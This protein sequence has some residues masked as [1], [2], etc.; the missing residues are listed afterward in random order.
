MG[1][2]VEPKTEWVDATVGQGALGPRWV[3][4]AEAF[5]PRLTTRHERIFELGVGPTMSGEEVFT[6][7]I[8]NVVVPE[9]LGEDGL[10]AVGT[11]VSAGDLLVGR[12]IFGA[13]AGEAPAA[14]DVSLRLPPWHEGEVVISEFIAPEK[15]ERARARVVVRW[16]RRLAV[17]DEF[18]L[19]DG[20]V[21]TVCDIRP[22]NTDLLFHEASPS[23]RV[24][25]HRSAKDVLAARSTGPC[26]LITQQPPGGRESLGGQHVSAL[27]AR[28]LISAGGPWVV[29]E[30]LTMKADAVAA[31][32]G[33]FQALLR[34]EAPGRYGPVVSVE[35]TNTIRA[36][37]S[38]V[39]FDL[40][41]SGGRVTAR[42]MSADEVRARSNGVVRTPE[43]I[44]PRTFRG[45][46]NGLF[47]ER[48][49]GPISSNACA[50]GQYTHM[51][52]PGAVCEACGV[53]VVASSV[54]RERFGHIELPVP[55][56]HPWYLADVAAL[57]GVDAEEVLRMPSA[58]L[59][60]ELA[61]TGE[62]AVLL[63]AL[64]VLPPDL[65]PIVPLDGGRLA[66][67]DLNE[68]YRRVVNTSI[69]LGRL[70]ELQAPTMIVENERVLLFREIA[71]LFSNEH[72]PRR[73]R[74][75]GPNH[76]A[77][78]SLVGVVGG[79]RE[80]G[81]YAK[82][83]DFSGVA[84]LVVD[85]TLDEGTCRV[86]ERMAKVL[87]KPF[88]FGQLQ[89]E[90]HETTIQ[91]AWR[92]VDE[93]RPAPLGAIVTVSRD[94]PVV[95]L[96]NDRLVSRRIR[97]WDHDAIALDP[98]TAEALGAPCEVV[99]H[100]PLTDEARAECAAWQAPR[101]LDAEPARGGWF[102]AM[103]SGGDIP[104]ALKRAA[105]ETEIDTL[106]DDLT[107]LALGFAPHL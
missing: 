61:R 64:P 82:N 94:R 3:V 67:S 107:R 74:L 37:I 80:R 48:I 28:A 12:V 20:R 90:G 7:D 2:D 96:A 45:Q 40:D 50:C 68:L 14:R 95:L 18:E 31:R 106:D 77:L 93:G 85:P 9:F 11:Q 98:K 46:P 39:G 23:L 41:W 104:S 16:E 38:A 42:R 79:R 76:V 19:E 55:I 6:N 83:V 69:R 89:A 65:R 100:V 17:G 56:P 60:S 97:L 63:D 24:K 54:R 43:T 103:M 105:H 99:L 62:Q 88:V 34:R 91:S 81:F 8:P 52:H 70:M 26:S 86:S 13:A 32:A 35:A 4:V 15:R 101:S 58:T 21:V 102:T 33:V 1:E 66:T 25:K 75:E 47:C 73:E 57:L 30:M 49:F 44:D 22:L 27:Q 72:L 29:G 78:M 87:F 36:A 59:E 5:A 53:M 71:R 92:G 10:V 51:L 84:T